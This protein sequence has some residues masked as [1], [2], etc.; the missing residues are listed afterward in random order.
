MWSTLQDLYSWVNE[1]DEA[2]KAQ[3]DEFL[4]KQFHKNKAVDEYAAKLRNYQSELAN[5]MEK[6]LTDRSL[7]QQLIKGLLYQYDN[8]ITTIRAN[9]LEFSQGIKML[10]EREHTLRQRKQSKALVAKSEKASAKAL[11]GTTESSSQNQQNRKPHW[12]NNRGKPYHRRDQRGYQPQ[13]NQPPPRT[14]YDP[15]KQCWYCARTGHLQQECHN[16]MNAE[17]LRKEG[18]QAP[19]PVSRRLFA[20]FAHASIAAVQNDPTLA[21]DINELIATGSNNLPLATSLEDSVRFN[22]D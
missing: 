10:N 12:K 15:K 22:A 1:D 11:V 21:T 5:I 4:D 3:Y 18:P 17:K 16:R 20:A 7:T 2:G 14:I 9:K 13:G 8:I 6:W 19:A